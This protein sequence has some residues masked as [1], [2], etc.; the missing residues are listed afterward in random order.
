[1]QE[2]NKCARSHIVI[3]ASLLRAARREVVD[4][5]DARFVCEAF[6]SASL[7]NMRTPTFPYFPNL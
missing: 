6:M 7:V 2:K 1:M 5:S 4:F 3:A